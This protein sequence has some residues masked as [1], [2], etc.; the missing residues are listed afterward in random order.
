[1]NSDS[2]T[3]YSIMLRSS[4]SSR[5]LTRRLVHKRYASTTTTTTRSTTVELL[6]DL[7]QLLQQQQQQRNQLAR[8][9]SETWLNRLNHVV[10]DLQRGE[11]RNN[12]ISSTS[13][14]LLLPALLSVDSGAN[15]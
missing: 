3:T 9:V 14:S 11:K 1:M 7:N 8:V 4:S 10:Q 12:R 13:S 6:S 5:S 2:T 15:E